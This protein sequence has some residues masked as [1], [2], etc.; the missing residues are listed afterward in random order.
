MSFSELVAECEM[1][2][3]RITNFVAERTEEQL[4]RKAQIPKLK[5]SPLG[6]YHVQSHIDHLREILTFSHGEYPG[7]N[8]AGTAK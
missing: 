2:Y 8:P 4:A 7:S 3:Q 5:D 6:E 1:N